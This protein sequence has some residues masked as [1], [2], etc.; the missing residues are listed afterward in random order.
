MAGVLPEVPAA[1]ADRVGP[2]RPDLPGGRGRALQAR[3]EGGRV[4]PARRRALR[5]G[6]RRGTDRSA[7]ARLPRPAPPGESPSRRSGALMLAAVTVADR[8][9]LRAFPSAE[10]VFSR[11]LRSIANRLFAVA[12]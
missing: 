3:P 12:L 10:T 1:D 4:P 2:E 9:L 8:G 11:L 7:H 6:K 5:S